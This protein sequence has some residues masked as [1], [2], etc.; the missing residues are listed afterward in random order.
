MLFTF[1]SKPLEPSFH[2]LV[3]FLIAKELYSID[4]FIAKDPNREHLSSDPHIVY[5]KEFQTLNC[6]LCLL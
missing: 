4:H 5:Q 2:L 3:P 1:P 6:A